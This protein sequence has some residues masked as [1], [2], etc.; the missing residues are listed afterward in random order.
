LA[1]RVKF[2]ASLLAD[3][4]VTCVWNYAEREYPNDAFW[5]DIR[6]D[7]DAWALE[8][9]E[10]GMHVIDEGETKTQTKERE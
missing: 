10:L 8:Q 4:G 5:E 2:E 6:M 3:D 7:R 1:V 9:L